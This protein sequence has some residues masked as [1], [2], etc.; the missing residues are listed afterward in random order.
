MTN[1][2]L[3]ISNRVRTVLRQGLVKVSE[4]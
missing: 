4:L 2:T 1:S 3:T